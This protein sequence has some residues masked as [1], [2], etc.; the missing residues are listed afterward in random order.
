MHC[1]FVLILFIKNEMINTMKQKLDLGA[2][3]ETFLLTLVARAIETTYTHPLLNDYKSKEIFDE[4][5]LKRYKIHQRICETDVHSICQR[6]YHLDNEIK[7]FLTKYPNGTILDIGA[8]LDTTYYRCDNGTAHWIDLDMPDSMLIREQILPIPNKRV[9]YI[10]KSMLDY[11]WIDDIGNIDNG[12]LITVPGVLMYFDEESVKEFLCTISAKLK[13]AT[14]IF[15]VLSNTGKFYIT[16][17]LNKI[18]MQEAN[19]KWT[20]Y[21]PLEIEK[22]S[23][24]LKYV[25]RIRYFQEIPPT[26]SIITKLSLNVAGFMDMSQ[27][28]YFEFI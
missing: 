2:V 23:P 9:K 8:G 5:D 17:L 6:A 13:G 14:I 18:K 16:F 20:I 10:A 21:N 4:L 24:N 15:D 25:K 12:L 7:S 11:S 28:F 27:L 1:I 26:N 3:Q 22:W 19:L